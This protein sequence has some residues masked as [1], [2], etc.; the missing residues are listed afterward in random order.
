[1]TCFDVGWIMGEQGIEG[2][3][4]LGVCG[5]GVRVFAGGLS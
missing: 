4:L 5:V 3:R 1:V 2:L